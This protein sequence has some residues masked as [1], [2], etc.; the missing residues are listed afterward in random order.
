M[1]TN[2]TFPSKAASDLERAGTLDAHSTAV[3]RAGQRLD[4][5]RSWKGSAS[6]LSESVVSQPRNAALSAPDMGGLVNTGLSVTT[7]TVN[8]DWFSQNLYNQSIANLTRALDSD[9][10]LSRNDLITI[11]RTAESGGE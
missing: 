9:G 4:T 6:S 2:S 8:G 1:F 7:A 10:S 5:Y 11:F 3:D